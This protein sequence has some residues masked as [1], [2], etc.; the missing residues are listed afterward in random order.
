V[1]MFTGAMEGLL[2]PGL[3]TAFMLYSPRQKVEAEK[4]ET[5]RTES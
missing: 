4:R 3:E 5:V 1:I 2:R